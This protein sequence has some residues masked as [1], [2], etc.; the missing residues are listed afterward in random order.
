MLSLNHSLPSL[1]PPPPLSISPLTHLSTSLSPL[2]PFPL[3]PSLSPPIPLYSIG[4]DI[5]TN[6]ISPLFL[7]QVCYS[8]SIII[9]VI[10]DQS[11]HQLVSMMQQDQY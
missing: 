7:S 2:P 11:D 1:S 10:T 9:I 5:L 6:I 8:I 3:P 4:Y